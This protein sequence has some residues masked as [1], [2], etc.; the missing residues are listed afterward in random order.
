MI[1]LSAVAL[2]AAFAIGEAAGPAPAALMTQE[3]VNVFRRFSVDRAKV[4]EFYGDVLGLQLSPTLNM[5][6]GGQMSQ[7]HVGTSLFKFTNAG[8]GRQDKSGPVLD[9]TGLRVFTYFYADEAG[10]TRAFTSHGYPAPDFQGAAGT[11]SRDGHR[12]RRTMGGTRR[13]PAAIRHISKWA[14]RCRTSETKPS[15]LSR[16]RR[17]RRAAGRRFRVR[18]DVSIQARSEERQHPQSLGGASGSGGQYVH[19]RHPVRH[20]RRGSRRR[21]RQRRPS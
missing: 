9:V 10:V 4:L 6:G 5:P 19:G 8:A 14:R 12:S 3:S 1:K 15:L 11:S 13:D 20:Q 18:Q 16:V 2:A 7:F 17:A 21:S